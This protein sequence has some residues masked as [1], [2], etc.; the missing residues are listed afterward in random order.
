MDQAS[1]AF[2][3]CTVQK[4]PHSS[5]L[6]SNKDGRSISVGIPAIYLAKFA[7]KLAVAGALLSLQVELLKCIWYQA[8]KGLGIVTSRS[9]VRDVV[10]Y[11][12]ECAMPGLQQ[13]TSQFDIPD[14]EL[15]T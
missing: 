15:R 14:F 13:V 5:Y 7:R 10:G 3:V 6:H 8:I 1:D 4:H 2:R 12:N 9:H 11:L